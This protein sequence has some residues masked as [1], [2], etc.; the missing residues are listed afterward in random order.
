MPSMLGRVIRFYSIRHNVFDPKSGTIVERRKR[1]EDLARSMRAPSGVQVESL[2]AN[3]VPGEWLIPRQAAPGK[4]LL[5]FHGGGWVMCSTRTHRAMVGRLARAAGIKALSIDYRLAPE[6]PYPAA[7]DDCLAAYQWLLDQGYPA[8]GIVVAGD[9]AG[10]NLTLALLL[11]L[12]DGAGPLPAAVVCLSPATDL[13]GTGASMQTKADVDPVLI[14]PIG[15]SPIAASY[16]GDHDLHDP[17]ISPLYGD[18]H[19]LPPVLIHVGE[20]E[21]LLDDSVRFAEKACAAGVD[22]RIV[23]WKNRFHVFQAYAPFIPDAQKSINQ[24]GEF[25]RAQLQIVI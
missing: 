2:T 8:S 21:V 14:L 4:V 9:S 15:S 17:Y 5:Y 1:I 24:I 12:R 23:I 11:K 16:T 20:D 13:A 22:A 25:I 19:G 18:L 3:G 10:G 7:L 6:Y